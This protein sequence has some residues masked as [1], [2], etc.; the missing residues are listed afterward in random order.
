MNTYTTFE[1]INT[2][3]RSTRF[4]AAMAFILFAMNSFF[5]GGT[6]AFVSVVGIATAYALLA[7]IGWCPFV[8]MI[9]KLKSVASHASHHGDH[10]PH[11]H[12][13]A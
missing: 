6:V 1:N 12:H 11:G 13:A 8:A 2:V 3:E 9:N 4:A 10:F 5:A 7:I